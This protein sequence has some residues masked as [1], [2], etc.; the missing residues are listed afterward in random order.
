ML[1][2]R[3]ARATPPVAGRMVGEISLVGDAKP[4]GTLDGSVNFRPA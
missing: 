2:I 3:S 1:N 4:Q